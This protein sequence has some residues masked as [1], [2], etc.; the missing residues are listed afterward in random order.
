MNC[1]CCG[2]E[3]IWGG[4]HDDEDGEGREMIVSNLSC[5]ECDAFYLVYWNVQEDTDVVSQVNQTQPG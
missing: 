3:V 4:D 5:P 1:Y 2:A